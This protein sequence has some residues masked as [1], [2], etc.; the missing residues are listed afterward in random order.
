MPSSHPSLVLSVFFLSFSLQVLQASHDAILPPSPGESGTG[1]PSVMATE[2]DREDET[3]AGP[4]L[5]KARRGGR[6]PRPVG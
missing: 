4:R 2:S 3:V 6:A 5:K 1:S